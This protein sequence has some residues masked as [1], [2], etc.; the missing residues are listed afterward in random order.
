VKFVG[1]VT[2]H[3]VDLLAT[4]SEALTTEQPTVVKKV[5]CLLLY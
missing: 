4:N 5:V 2:C 3:C 1:L